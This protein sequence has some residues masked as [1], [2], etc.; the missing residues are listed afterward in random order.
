MKL[1]TECTAKAVTHHLSS[2]ARTVQ[3]VEVG[4]VFSSQLLGLYKTDVKDR[5]DRFVYR[6]LYGGNTKVH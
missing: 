6:G 5:P 3:P 1:N 4:N 2:K